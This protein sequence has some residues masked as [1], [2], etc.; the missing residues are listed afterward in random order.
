MYE[1]FA[2]IYDALIDVDY[3]AW[4]DGYERL[5]TAYGKKPCMV[6]DLACGSG[7]VAIRLSARGYDMTAIDLSPDM[8]NLA[9]EKAA[10]KELDILFLEQD[11]T[12][13]ELYGTVDA[14]VSSLD[15]INYLLSEEEVSETFHWV[16]NYLM[17]GGLFIFDINSPYKLQ[18]VLGNQTYVY[19]EEGIFY[20]WENEYD[21]EEE[22]CSFYLNIFREE[23]DGRYTRI[24]EEQAEKVY[25]V[26]TL[27]RLLEEN[28][29][30]VEAVLGE[31]MKTAPT[32]E[33]ERIFFVARAHNHNKEE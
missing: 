33:S 27:H 9:R 20:T 17:D 14:V 15:S 32:P 19:E 21:E 11:M 4:V 23:E 25:S 28:S 10:E 2:P 26:E 29:M 30:T 31:D 5:F 7:E 3:D 6:L 16:N 18:H 22:I 1:D 12:S 24:T 13:F 8:L